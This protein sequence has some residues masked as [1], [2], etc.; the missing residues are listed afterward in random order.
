VRSRLAGSAGSI[1][2][3]IGAGLL[4][5]V[6]ALVLPT[7][8]QVFLDGVVGERRQDW[9]VP[10]LCGVGASGLLTAAL[11]A[12][13]RSQFRRLRLALS[14]R[15]ASRFFW[16][17]IRLPISFYSQRFAGEIASRSSL[18]E[19]LAHLLSGALASTAIDLVMMVFFAAL[20]FQY[21]V[22]LTSIGIAAA[23]VNVFAL[24][25]LG[26]RCVEPNMRL[27][28][29]SGMV[30]GES[31]AALCSME[32]LKASG[33]ES[34]FFAKWSGHYAKATNT[35]QELELA[36]T[37][38]AWVPR[39]LAQATTATVL[40]VG[41]LRVIDGQITIG[42]LVAFQALM[43]SFMAPVSSV[44]QLGSTIQTLE[45][46]LARLDDVL[47]NP[48]EA[49]AA[50][51]SAGAPAPGAPAAGGDGPP[52]LVRLAGRVEFRNVSFGY[53]PLDP[54]LIEDFDL[55]IRPG[56]RVA[57]VGGSGS[58]KTTISNLMCGL[59][60][61]RSGVIAFD[62][63]P[64][65]EVPR[66]LMLNS[67]AAVGQDIFLFA[68]TVRENLTL[69]DPTVPEENLVRAC[70]DAG[71][72]DVVLAL[73]GGFDGMLLE[74]GINLSG[75]QRQRLEI[76]RALVHNP[77]ILVL[78]EATSALDSETEAA[79]DRN[80][81]LRGC[82]CLI[83]AHRLSTIRDSDE[84]LVLDRGQVVERGTHE[85]LWAADGAYAALIRTTGAAERAEGGA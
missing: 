1:A 63:I 62:G 64:R 35:R 12:L 39:F 34:G 6:P 56:Q 58:G 28:R 50:G 52:S 59:Y 61:P 81:R 79:V 3:C 5:A 27:Q 71:V 49:Q 60:S 80:L 44:V 10:V 9:L 13:Q 18:N 30:Y 68:G 24:R 73:P 45:G 4:L 42:M 74:G 47:A 16:H 36:N 17:L 2:F 21:D 84:I 23:A 78:D 66:A 85:Q 31:I 67:F 43:A 11:T 76:A 54:P 7:F 48:V 22:V 26:Q 8:T 65:A 29:D 40:L 38:L 25:R 32:T 69:W 15:L 55:D 20:M 14:V 46:T 83:V 77:S 41:G 70:A 51:G 75:G 19:E 37:R 57:L 53:S 72:L 33:Q 82:T